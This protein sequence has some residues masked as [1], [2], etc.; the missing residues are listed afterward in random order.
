MR[1]SMA[2]CSKSAPLAYCAREKTSL[3]EHQSGKGSE[4]K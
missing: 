3:C 2:S 4:P 1:D